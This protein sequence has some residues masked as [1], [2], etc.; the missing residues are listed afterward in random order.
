M[1]LVLASLDNYAKYNVANECNFDCIDIYT[2]LETRLWRPQ[3]TVLYAPKLVNA[4]S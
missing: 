1:V 2:R 4:G 3:V